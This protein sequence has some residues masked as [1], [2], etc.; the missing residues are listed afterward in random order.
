MLLVP[1]GSQRDPGRRGRARRA[2]RSSRRSGWRSRSRPSRRAPRPS[3]SSS[4]SGSA[5]STARRPPGDSSSSCRR[6]RAR[7]GVRSR[8]APS[9]RAAL[10][11]AGRAALGGGERLGPKQRSRPWSA[12]SAASEPSPA[13]DDRDALRRLAARGLVAPHAR[14]RSRRRPAIVA[15]GAPAGRAAPER[16]SSRWRSS[17]SPPASTADGGELLLHGVTGSGKTEV[18]LA[19]AAAALERGRG[20]IVLVPEI[21]LTPQTVA[22]F[23]SRAS[24]TGSPSS[25]RR[26][27]QG[28]RRDEWQRLRR[29]EARICVGP[30]SAVFAPVAGLG[31]IVVDEEHDASYKQEGDPRY[32]ARDVAARRRGRVGG[33]V[34]V[35]GTATPRPESWLRLRAPRAARARRRCARCRRSRS[36]TCASATVAPGRCTPRTRA[37]LRRGRRA[38]RQGDRAGQPPRMVAPSELPLVRARLALPELRRLAGRSTAAAARSRCHHCGHARAGA[39]TRARECGSVTARPRTAPAPS[40][41]RSWSPGSSSRC[42]SSGSTPMRPPGAAPTP[43]ILAAFDSATAGVLVGTQMVAKGHDFPDVVLSVVARRRL[44][45]CGSPTSAPRSGRSPSSRSSPGAAAAAPAGGRVLV[46]TLAPGAEAISARG[47]PRRA[48]ASS[49]ASSSAAASSRYP[50]FSHLIRIELSAPDG[51]GRDDA[52]A[53]PPPRLR[54]LLPGDATLLGPGAAVSPARPRAPPDP[55]EG[56]R[57]RP[58]RGRRPRGRRSGRARA[59][60]LRGVALAVDVDPQ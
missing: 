22:R 54:P 43:A 24:A 13:G 39:R 47:A 51:R 58:R 7:P 6:G 19:A 12:C 3:R 36:S 31:L 57:A 16:R 52:A 34:L 38:R 20:A 1:F 17:A 55:G 48:P 18:Y 40:G 60:A 8:P 42:R 46:Q 32:D 37:A 30:R 2:S 11:D 23:Q 27:S 35:A 25:T 15:V 28:E 4:A 59:R 10:T 9:S 26:L 29:G 53:R 5:A 45:A 44:D 56:A 49:R 41:S 21:A 50:P 14:W 33:A